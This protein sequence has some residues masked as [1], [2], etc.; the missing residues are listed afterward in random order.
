MHLNYC[1]QSVVCHCCIKIS[2]QVS[3]LCEGSLVHAGTSVQ[4]QSVS[5]NTAPLAQSALCEP[6]EYELMTAKRQNIEK[7]IILELCFL[8]HNHCIETHIFLCE[9]NIIILYDFLEYH[10]TVRS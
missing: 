2:Y 5:D 1:V 8:K 9:E 4:R 3:G 7:I 10:R 6:S